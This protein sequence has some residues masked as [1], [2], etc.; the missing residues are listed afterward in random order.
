MVKQADHGP[1]NQS[2]AAESGR[3]AETRFLGTSNRTTD[4]TTTDSPKLLV[5]VTA[6]LRS[7][8]ARSKETERES[9]RRAGGPAAWLR[10][11]APE[12]LPLYPA[13][14]SESE[15]FAESLDGWLDAAA[16][17]R[18]CGKCPPEGGACDESHNAWDDGRIIVAD[19]ERGIRGAPC[20]KWE[21][22]LVWKMLAGANVPE[23]LRAARPVQTL[24]CYEAALAGP[25]A[26]ARSHGQKHWYF[27]T[28]GDARAHRHAL[29][30]LMMEL[31]AVHGRN[32]WYD[33]SAR[34]AVALRDHMNDDAAFDLRHKL[35]TVPIL[36]IDHLNPT[37]WKP[38]FLEAMDEI[39]FAREGKVTLVA[40]SR[41]VLDLQAAFPLSGMV[42]E[43]AVRVE[44]G[45]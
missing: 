41:S 24:P 3:T 39:L 10:R 20:P 43:Q 42:I 29:V 11:R 12:L 35:R 22:W 31:G 1:G 7:L 32:F 17:A 28:G 36:A 4:R 34:I 5:E 2:L 6:D 13:G 33:W 44:V 45:G 9:V 23:I 15:F 8:R 18:Q 30:T 37:D 26:A 25:L 14:P 40:S 19:P 38:W 27:V 16:R 21:R